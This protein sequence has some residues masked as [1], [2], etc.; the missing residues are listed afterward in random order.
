[1]NRSFT[2][3]L[4]LC[5]LVLF[6]ACSHESN[7]RKQKSFAAGEDA[8]SKGN[9][10]EAVAQYSEAIK[11]D[12]SFVQAHYKLSQAYLRMRDVNDAF[13]ELKRT[14]ALDPDNYRAQTD[15]ANMLI[16]S[17]NPDNL[18]EAKLHLDILRAKQ[19][20]AP[21]THQSWA[22]FDAAQGDLKSAIDESQQSIAL[23]PNRSES[24]LQLALFQLANNQPDQAE[25]SFKKAVDV[26]PKAM[27]PQLALGTFY[28]SVN[29]MPEAEKQFQHAIE[30][31]PTSIVP[32]SALMRLL[33]REGKAADAEAVAVKSKKDLPDNP[34]VYRMPGDFY[35]ATNNLDKAAAEY[36]SLYKDHPQD[37]QVMRKYIQ[38]LILQKEDRLDE[39]AKLNNQIL[40][41]NPHDSEALT[42]KA[43]IQLRQNDAPGAIA[44]LQSA[45]SSDPNNAIAHDQ[46]GQAF[47]QQHDDT[48]AEQ[49]WR[50]AL[51]LRP[52]LADAQ[53][54]IALLENQR[55]GSAHIKTASST[56]ASSKPALST[57]H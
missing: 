38:I 41:S 2:R 47:H 19:P 23:N 52:D 16:A 44:S 35:I 29:R 54:K 15:L 21:E 36:A 28:Q 24:Y 40:Q 39:A 56:S 49:E 7:A 37:Q 43:Q 17:R 50:R 55:G 25:A 4:P 11:I 9:Y 8:F 13:Q 31:D 51:A 3:L 22:T 42:F 30:V 1:M 34:D 5:A 26:D 46:L 32:R 57:S 53:Q 27:R 33:M 20:N 10:S 45:I 14:I 6:S 12:S 48:H 18:K